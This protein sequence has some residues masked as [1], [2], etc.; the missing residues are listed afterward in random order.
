MLSSRAQTLIRSSAL[1]TG[2]VGLRSSPVLA[3]VNVCANHRM[4]SSSAHNNDW[5][6]NVR[7]MLVLQRA[8]TR[9]QPKKNNPNNG[10]SQGGRNKYAK[11][12]ASAAD[13]LT[14]MSQLIL[15]G[16]ALGFLY[17]GIYPEKVAAQLEAYKESLTERRHQNM[18]EFMSTERKYSHGDLTGVFGD[19]NSNEGFFKQSLM[20]ANEIYHE[21]V[22]DDARKMLFQPPILRYGIIT[23]P[24]GSGKSRLMRTLCHEQPYY[25][26]LS[27][28]L[29]SS[30]KSIVE[31]LSQEIGYDFDDW[32]ER[33]LQG[34]FFKTSGVPPVQNQ[35]DKLAFLL[36]E[37]E[38]A[39]W[40]LKFNP[41]TGKTGKRPV[42][43]LD[44]LDSLDFGDQDVAKATRMLFNAANKWAR[45]DTALVCFTL[46]DAL[47]DTLVKTNIV[48]PDVISTAQ[49]YRV[50]DL[51]HKQATRFL[52][53]SLGM[54]SFG[55]TPTQPSERLI[56]DLWKI[57]SVVGTKINDLLRISEELVKKDGAPGEEIVHDHLH[58]VLERELRSAEDSIAHNLSTISE[59]VGPKKMRKVLEF[60]DHVSVLNKKDKSINGQEQVRENGW[61]FS[62]IDGSG[63]KIWEEARQNGLDLSLRLLRETEVLGS[64]GLF[65]SDL[66]RNGYRRYRHLPPLF[67]NPHAK[68]HWFWF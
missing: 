21:E 35:L 67:F 65:C 51:S 34:Y 54:T 25:A 2:N 20:F 60:L 16:S 47:L 36:D 24:A 3:N 55:T 12:P 26:F 53:N 17:A 48:R 49:V 44:D 41:T 14:T 19:S 4:L 28:G 58:T 22:A 50:G 13:V 30:A 63:S 68:K 10:D 6:A 27:F 52:Q 38:A 31:E 7:N 1:R 5:F 66:V 23:G 15:V 40:S 56:N 64:N 46:S 32:T 33:M 9:R 43:V 11:P 59:Q 8:V 37:F 18:L 39:C 45:E 42:L 29:T 57:K 62:D 61:N